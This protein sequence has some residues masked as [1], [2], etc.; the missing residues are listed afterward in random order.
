MVHADAKF[1]IG[2]N[3]TTTQL[4]SANV[5]NRS[6]FNKVLKPAVT[7]NGD[8]DSITAR[9]KGQF[10][11]LANKLQTI[12]GIIRVFRSAHLALEACDGLA[13]GIVHIEITGHPR[14]KRTD[15]KGKSHRITGF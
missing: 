5:K 9:Q 2:L 14:D 13:D 7:C 1:S 10:I 15:L 6:R 4:S 12:P 8:I 11:K 3:G